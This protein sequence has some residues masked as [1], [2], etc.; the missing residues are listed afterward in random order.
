M[1]SRPE[2]RS[3]GSETKMENKE[4]SKAY[5]NV[6]DYIKEEIVY[7]R[8]QPGQKLPPERNLAE[9]LS[10]GRNSV[11]EALR[12][13]D[14][15][16]IIESTQGAG[17][18]VSCNF[19]KSIVE[20]MSM[21]FMMQK[22]DYTQISELRQALESQAI[23]LAVDRISPEQISQLEEILAGMS[24][25]KDEHQGILL[26]TK[27]HFAIAQ[28]SRNTLIIEILQALSDLIDIF[29]SDLRKRILM[30]EEGMRKLQ[31]S[32]ELMLENLKKKNKR[33]AYNAMTE[34]YKIV[35]ENIENSQFPA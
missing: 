7:G 22:T 17:N 9:T 28:A 14:I 8:L 11:R 5:E 33:G 27:F 3:K 31:F 4:Q 16:G 30:S 12:T 32:H 35:N 26:D 24:V 20:S 23:I 10:V 18:F 25:G 19:K 34:H 29:I 15:I 6:I 1:R 21:M 2:Y 13:L